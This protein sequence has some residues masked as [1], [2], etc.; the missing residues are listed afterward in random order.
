MGVMATV[1]L[2]YPK[3]VVWTEIFENSNY[4][5]D[6]LEETLEIDGEVVLRCHGDYD[7]I[8]AH[9]EGFLSALRY[10]FGEFP[11]RHKVAHK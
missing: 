10:V 3:S 11:V 2:N 1:T 7:N 9:F 8:Q 6:P 5:G 4:D